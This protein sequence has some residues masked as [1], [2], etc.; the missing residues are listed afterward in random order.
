MRRF[1]PD[2]DPIGERFVNL[3]YR[4]GPLGAL[5]K[6]EWE[7]VGVVKDV[8]YDGIRADAQPAVYFSGLQSSLRRRTLVVRYGGASPVG[9]ITAVRGAVTSLQPSLALT[10]VRTLADVVSAAR[11]RDRF[12]TLLLALFGALALVLASVGVYGV[13]AY[14]VAQRTNEVGIR[15][16]LGADRRVVRGMVLGDGMKL[17][18]VGL[19]VG[20]VGALA[21]AGFLSSQLFGVSPRDPVVIGAVVLVL[22]AVGL[23]ASLVPAWR[24]TRVDPVVAMRAQ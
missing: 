10:N 14:A 1:L 24:A 18:V 8:K 23:L 13:L 3:G 19:A 4:F 15:M 20:L 7:I 17:V 6:S 22:F 21:L 2:E 5:N 11:S 16:A 12:S 9:L